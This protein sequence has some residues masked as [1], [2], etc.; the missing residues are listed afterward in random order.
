VV[1]FLKTYLPRAWFY[2]WLW[3]PAKIIGWCLRDNG[4][5][6]VSLFHETD[7]G[8]LLWWNWISTGLASEPREH[9]PTIDWCCFYYF[10]RNRLVVFLETLCA[11]N[12]R[13]TSTPCPPSDNLGGPGKIG[14]ENVV[15]CLFI[16]IHV[17]QCIHVGIHT[18]CH[19]THNLFTH[20][21]HKYI[22]M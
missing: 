4:A 12:C 15:I 19:I 6:C 1:N 11:K 21:H 3:K 5:M 16:F 18:I 10:V 22:L 13:R 9:A 17:F 2:F 8:E 14:K 20:T 7:I